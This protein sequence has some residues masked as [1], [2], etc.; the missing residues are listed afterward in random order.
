MSKQKKKPKVEQV[1]KPAKSSERHQLA[2][3]GNKFAVGNN[4]GRPREWTSVE[5]EKE[6]IALE[7]WMEN[8]KNYFF[9]NFL[10]IRK[11]HPEQI[12][13]FC[14]YNQEFRE[15]YARARRIQEERLVELAVFRK[16]DANFIKFVLQNKA[17]WKEKSEV[18]GDANNPLA[19]ILEKIA[20]NSRDPLQQDYDDE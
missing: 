16:G 8:P 3:K 15:S 11:L 5:I 13:R 19:V 4:G 10:N 17:G 2:M 6:R 14:T 20:A 18:S 1:K 12:E 7:E 9:T